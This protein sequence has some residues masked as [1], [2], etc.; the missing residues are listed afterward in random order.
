[1]YL[2]VMK[3]LLSLLAI[4]LVL[5]IVSCTE[6]KETYYEEFTNHKPL[7]SRILDLNKTIDEIKKEE[8][9]KLIKEDINFL[10]FVY[11]IGKN[12][13]Y[14]VS[15]LFDEK[16][17]YEIGIDGYFKLEKD[18]ENVVVGIQKEMESKKYGKGTNDNSLNQWKSSDKS[19]SIELDYKDSS[20]GLFVA[21]IFAN[22]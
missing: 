15:Y 21:T 10:K 4:T 6:N 20:S 3:K 5:I 19:I 9:G 12:D 1:M 14:M 7:V 18:A 2:W 11:E 8:K 17:C 22:E 13:T 16:G